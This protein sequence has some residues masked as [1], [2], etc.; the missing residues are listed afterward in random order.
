MHISITTTTIAPEDKR[1]RV[2]VYL[3]QQG[4]P[5]YW[6]FHC[7]Q[8]GSKI[9]ELDGQLMYISDIDDQSRYDTSTM[10]RP[11]IVRCHSKFCR[12]WYEFSLGN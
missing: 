2:S 12:Y 1:Y 7:V 10:G 5:K 8:C 6:S 9:C 4:R 3:V 11:L